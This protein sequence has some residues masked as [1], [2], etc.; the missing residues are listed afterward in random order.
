M[1]HKREHR[2]P[3]PPLAR[4]MGVDRQQQQQLEEGRCSRVSGSDAVL[5]FSWRE[6]FTYVRYSVARGPRFFKWKML[7]ESGSYA[8]IFLQ[9][10]I[11][12]V[13]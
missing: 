1:D 12:L 11:A 4:V 13:T 3:P 2:T 6:K 9:F 10:F 5:I 7:R 8:L